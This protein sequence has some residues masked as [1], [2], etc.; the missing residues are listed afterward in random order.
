MP[1]TSGESSQTNV[2]KT[3]YLTQVSS[4]EEMEDNTGFQ[5]AVAVKQEVTDDYGDDDI[6]RGLNDSDSDEND[7]IP[8]HFTPPE[9]SDSDREDSV[10]DEDIIE[11]KHIFDQQG[12]RYRVQVKSEPDT[13]DTGD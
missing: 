10:L 13:K 6:F 2:E 12:G 5:A 11:L 3:L 8:P 7:D 9:S 1:S 4:D